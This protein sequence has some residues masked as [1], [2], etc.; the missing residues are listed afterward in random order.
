MLL[1]NRL[2]CT[3]SFLGNCLVLLPLSNLLLTLLSIFLLLLLS[4]FFL[5][6]FWGFVSKERILILLGFLVL[7]GRVS[8]LVHVIG[9]LNPLRFL[10]LLILILLWHCWGNKLAMRAHNFLKYLLTNKISSIS[11][12]HI[13]LGLILFVQIFFILSLLFQLFI[14]LGLLMEPQLLHTYSL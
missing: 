12:I 4:S 11:F 9:T 13:H 6:I 8:S 10:K 5:L 7:L 1:R 3:S 2:T 14:L